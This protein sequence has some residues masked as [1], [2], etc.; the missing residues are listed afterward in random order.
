MRLFPI[1][2][3]QIDIDLVT[4]ITIAVTQP[5]RMRVRKEP[6]WMKVLS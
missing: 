5:K 1:P 2:P 4:Q 3:F 6:D